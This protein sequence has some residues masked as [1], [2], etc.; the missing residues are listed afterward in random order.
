MQ[1]I[2]MPLMVSMVLLIPTLAG[3]RETEQELSIKE[4][5]E[6]EAGKERLYS[7]PF[8]FSGH[9]HPEVAEEVE[10]VS[11]EHS[12]HGAFRSDEKSCEVAFLSAIRELQAEALRK[13]ADGIVDIV[14]I[15][16]GKELDSPTNH[17]CVAGAFVVHVGL[18]GKLVNFSK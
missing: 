9:N 5:V 2:L 13:D 7:I 17:R 15:A 8:Y 3:A 10:V 14:S 11:A 16:F 18:R 4:A 6:G 12:T 1:R